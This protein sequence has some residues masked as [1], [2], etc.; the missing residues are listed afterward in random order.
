MDI[1]EF[2]S[3]KDSGK[4]ESMT[5]GSKRDTQEGKPRPDLIN[6]LVLRRLSMHFAG[7]C[8]KYG[9]RNYELGQPT[10]RYKASEGRHKLDYD[11]G[12][13]D[14]DH[15]AARIWNLMGIMMNEEFIKRGIY[16]PEM[17]D[18]TDYRDKEGFDR[19][20]GA[21]ALAF[22]EAMDHSDPQPHSPGKIELQKLLTIRQ[23]IGYCGD[24]KP[25][26]NC[27]DCTS[28]DCDF[29]LAE[30]VPD[31]TPNHYDWTPNRQDPVTLDDEIQSM[32]DRTCTGCQ[33][34]KNTDADWPCYECARVLVPNGNTGEGTRHDFY[35]PAWPFNDSSFNLGN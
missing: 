30:P 26:A 20:V 19:T 7:G 9:E 34:Q 10:S 2:G 24:T 22:N 29:N 13:R 14:E 32:E 15:L 25:S 21:R 33:H 23:E 16:P 35:I 28:S 6:P 18:A 3:I 17:D 1:K 31:L 8:D 27:C 4:R 11:E 5:T 12:L